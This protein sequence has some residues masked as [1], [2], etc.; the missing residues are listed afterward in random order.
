MIEHMS[1]TRRRDTRGAFAKRGGDVPPRRCSDG[2]AKA[3]GSAHRTV[4][5]QRSSTDEDLAVVLGLAP[6]VNKQRSVVSGR[7][8]SAARLADWWSMHGAQASGSGP[9]CERK[10]LLALVDRNIAGEVGMLVL[11]HQDRLALASC[12]SNISVPGIRAN[13]WC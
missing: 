12:S 8:F 4:T 11:A 1:Y 7:V 3:D 2:T 6:P 10:P 9:N 13:S 5:N